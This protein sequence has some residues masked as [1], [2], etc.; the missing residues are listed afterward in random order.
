MNNTLTKAIISTKVA[1]FPFETPDPFLFCVYHKDF[2][3]PGN[4]KNMNAPVK[5]N[6]N[7][8]G[9]PR[10]WNMY[11]GTDI[12]GF[13]SHPH[14][15]FETITA[16][17]EGSIDHTDSRYNGGRFSSYDVQ[18]M[19][20]G[21]GI[22]HAE[23]FPLIKTD[24]PNTLRFFQ[25]WLNLPRKSKMVEP[26]FTMHWKERAQHVFGTNGAKATV[27]AGRLGD[28]VGQASPPDSWAADPSHDVGVYY[29]DLP[30]SSSFKLPPALGGTDV[31]RGAWIVEGS[32][33]VAESRKF[34]SM[35]H[36]KLNANIEIEFENTGTDTGGVLVLQGKPINEPVAQH[37]PFV[38]NTREEIVE[39]FNDYRKTQF[40]G[41]P[42]PEDGMA[43]N[44]EKGR[45]A[46]RKIGNVEEE[47]LP[48]PS[49][50]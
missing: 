14:R 8:F 13:P 19:T 17:L 33:M 23:M 9:N 41:W 48:P 7:D 30:P 2:Y 35:T 46:M 21:K 42:W 32:G 11:H 31:H 25:I 16:V 24:E 50:A 37:G 26:Y 18:W 39:A 20:A 36:L 43:W 22:V 38:M 44:R 47:E 12:P 10:G 29:I 3:P 40:G 27:F 34:P 15:G 4:S 6:G 49:L 5:G 1:G 45:F 28:S